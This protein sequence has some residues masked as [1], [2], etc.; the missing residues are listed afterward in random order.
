VRG[1]TLRTHKTFDHPSAGTAPL[2]AP[3]AVLAVVT[4]LLFALLFM[5]TP[6]SM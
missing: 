5:P 6:I 2:G 1:G 3:R 4:L